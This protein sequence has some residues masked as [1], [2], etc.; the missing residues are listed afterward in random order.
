MNRLYAGNDISITYA[1]AATGS[2]TWTARLQTPSGATK[3]LSVSVSAPNIT[4]TMDKDEWPDGATGR[5]YIEVIKSVGGVDTP[6]VYAPVRIMG[7]IIA[8]ASAGDY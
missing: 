6:A 1:V 5:G 2:E 7:S 3:D 8:G 4:V